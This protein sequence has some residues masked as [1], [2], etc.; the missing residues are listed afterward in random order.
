MTRRIAVVPLLC[1][2]VTSASMAV[3][4]S[5]AQPAE[6][7][8]TLSFGRGLKTLFATV[9]HDRDVTVMADGTVIA[10]NPATNVLVARRNRDGSITTRCMDNE[11]AARAFFEAAVQTP[12]APASSPVK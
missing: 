6:R 11:A 1:L 9:A 12:A 7:P 8:L 5:A 2:F 10:G 4:R 3:E